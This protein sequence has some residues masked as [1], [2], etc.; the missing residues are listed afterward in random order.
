MWLYKP[1]S[2]IHRW[3]K[4]LP[5]QRSILCVNQQKIFYEIWTQDQSI[6][7]RLNRRALA[8]QIPW[9][10]LR[11]RAIRLY[12]TVV[13]YFLLTYMLLCSWWWWWRWKISMAAMLLPMATEWCLQWLSETWELNIALNWKIVGFLLCVR[14]YALLLVLMVGN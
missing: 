12:Q 3:T 2:P 7:T 11:L 13:C 1:S 9:C 4:L 8:T 5:T 14:T 6:E 10:G